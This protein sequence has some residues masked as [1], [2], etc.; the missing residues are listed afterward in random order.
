MT[1]TMR[2]HGICPTCGIDR[3]LRGQFTAELARCT[4]FTQCQD[5]GGIVPSRSSLVDENEAGFIAALDERPDDWR[6]RLIYS[7]WLEE[8][9]RLDEAACQRWMERTRFCPTKSAATPAWYLVRIGLPLRVVDLAELSGW[10]YT[11]QKAEVAL[12]SHLI[13]LLRE[14]ARLAESSSRSVA[15][16]S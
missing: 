8:Q 7:D 6:L 16:K 12:F 3:G 13:P 4:R 15:A 10:F 1:L 14:S 9:G 2:E 11:R 5:C